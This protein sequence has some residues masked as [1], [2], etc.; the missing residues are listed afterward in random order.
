MMEHTG[1]IY[2]RT[3]NLLKEKIARK[4]KISSALSVDGAEVFTLLAFEMGRAIVQLRMET[5]WEPNVMRQLSCDLDE[6]FPG[7]IYLSKLHQL[8]DFYLG[9][10]RMV[11]CLNWG[12][13]IQEE[14]REK[15][16]K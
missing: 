9:F 2:Q 1:T 8:A 10:E 5:H 7:R 14:D 4:E 12:K 3:L 13:K 6:T 11:R 16:A 15:Q